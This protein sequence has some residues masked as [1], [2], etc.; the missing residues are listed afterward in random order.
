MTQHAFG[1]ARD[2]QELATH[3]DGAQV[4]RPM[5]EGRGNAR[6]LMEEVEQ[7]LK[8]RRQQRAAADNQS[9]PG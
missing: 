1:A 5:G 2:F 6:Q 7:A 4:A 9:A 3:L 8:A